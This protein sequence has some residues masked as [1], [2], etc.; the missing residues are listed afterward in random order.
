MAPEARCHEAGRGGLAVGGASGGAGGA[1]RGEE[2]DI[3][4]PMEGRK[5]RGTGKAGR[6]ARGG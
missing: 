2:I 3:E 1:G 5:M 4:L 6:S